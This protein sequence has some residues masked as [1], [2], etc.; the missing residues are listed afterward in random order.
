MERIIKDIVL[1]I[2]FLFRN[3]F[4]RS[5]YIIRKVKLDYVTSGE[6][7][8]IDSVFWKNE[9]RFW[10]SDEIADNTT[11]I[12]RMYRNKFKIDEPPSCVSDCLYRITYL[13]NNQVY[14]YMSG[15]H[16]HV[17]PPKK[18]PGFNPP[19][20][21]AWAETFDGSHDDVT[22]QIKKFAGPNSDFHG[23]TFSIHDML[24]ERYVRLRLINI[25]GQTSVIEEEV[26]FSRASLWTS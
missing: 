5:N 2:F 14:K 1:H 4:V 23:E 10:D 3:F 12:T 22:K 17:W 6:A 24:G 19:I 16:D 21:E 8:D 13:Y 26:P 15:N 18:V 11:D 9:A 25:L 20:K 7:S